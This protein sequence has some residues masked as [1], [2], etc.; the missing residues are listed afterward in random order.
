MPP[1]KK[2]R[3]T[4]NKKKNRG[5][6]HGRSSQPTQSAP[7]RPSRPAPIGPM[8]VQ[9]P[10]DMSEFERRNQQLHQDYPTV[11]RRYK[12]ATRRFFNYMEKQ[13][14]P[15]GSTMS[16]NT[17]MAIADKMYEEGRVV[18]P[19]AL[20]DLK[21]AIRVRNRVARSVYR[22]GDSGHQHLLAVLVYCW[23]VLETLPRSST[24]GTTETEYYEE[25]SGGSENRYAPLQ[26]EIEDDE[27]DDEEMDETVFPSAP[28]PRPEPE[29]EPM[30]LE[31]LMNSDE[32]HDSVLFLLSLEE[33]MA[34]VVQQY[35]VILKNHEFNLEAD[36][37][38]SAIIEELIEASV[39]TNMGIQ[40]VH[41]LEL[42]L[43]L[44]YPHLTN[45]YR[46]LATVVLPEVTKQITATLRQHA[47]VKCTEKDVIIFLGDCL[48]CSFRNISDPINR[49]KSIVPELCEQFQVDSQGEQELRR[50]VKA[51]HTMVIFEVPFFMEK[52]GNQQLV[53]EIQAVVPSLGSPS[54]LSMDHIGG[55]RA[56]HHTIRLLQSFGQIIKRTP[57][58]KEVRS[59]QN[60][61]FAPSPWIPG[62]SSSIAG[63]L[64]ELL[65]TDI[66]PHFVT[67]YR[68]GILA[69][70]ELPMMD[71]VAPFWVNIGN[72]IRHPEK[73]VSWTLAFSVHAMLTAVLETDRIFDSLVTLTE[74]M[75]D[76]FFEQVEWAQ[77][78]VKS[79]PDSTND[80]KFRHNTGIV[81]FLKNLGFGGR[82]KR[83]IWN[84]L[85]AGTIFSY[86]NFFGNLEV[87]STLL[88]NRAQLRII[89]YLFHGLLLNGIVRKGQVPFLDIIYECFK[90]SRAIWEGPMPRRGELVQRF[91][92][93]F[94]LNAED[95]RKLA[96]MAQEWYDPGAR[97]NGD[98]RDPTWKRRKM[99]ALEPAEFSKSYRRVCNR[100]FHDVVDNYHT[101]EQRQRNNGRDFYKL[102]VRTNDTLDAI[103][104][105]QQLLSL[106]FIPCGAILEQFVCSLV[107]IMQWDPLIK[108]MMSR[109][110]RNGGDE[111]RQG[112]VHL[113]AL[114][115]LGALDFAA[116][117]MD[118]EFLEVPL[119]RASSHFLTVFFNNLDPRRAMWFQAVSVVD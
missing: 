104:E 15:E 54:W 28:V 50:L 53:S 103:D 68:H 70:K 105:E 110:N 23:T 96:R 74:T 25:V 108:S 119:G 118:Q 52:V 38:Q 86:I 45:P 97:H 61:Y 88:D 44:Q 26:G 81:L 7:A 80:L 84:P 37:P 94:G 32:R 91:W 114:H 8:S 83:A 76:N 64:D 48:E 71:E 109:S 87:G 82:G 43:E 24:K 41:K 10:P 18:D 101:P 11:Y 5:A 63:E 89:M 17:I 57:L 117:P 62:R 78:V 4:N 22:G 46:V 21:L 1:K 14:V 36:V 102:T 69:I 72:Y 92:M 111:H 100:D 13:G 113:F 51:V 3:Q 16:V 33:I 20:K 55:T 90:N 49:A 58:D 66:L 98:R 65:M 112:A 29:L 60:G 34:M 93:C 79:E 99:K 2:G 116:D 73:T 31:E 19:M 75:F 30:S 95:S 42:D 59:C 40:Q 106:N 27:E 47:S 107:R 115:L 85:C 39:A 12:D 35:Q 77:E 9:T 56:I 6:G 67:M